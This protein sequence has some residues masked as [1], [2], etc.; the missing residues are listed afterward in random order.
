MVPR[1]EY[2]TLLPEGATV[3]RVRRDSDLRGRNITVAPRY[4]VSRGLEASDEREVV[5][6][7]LSPSVTT[8]AQSTENFPHRGDETSY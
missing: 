7:D 5:V 1:E 6:E 8:E 4:S 2:F 3:H